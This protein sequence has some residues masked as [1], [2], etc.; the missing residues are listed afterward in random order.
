MCRSAIAASCN[1]VAQRYLSI[2]RYSRGVV[3]SR[4]EVLVREAL[5]NARDGGERV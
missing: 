4:I 3:I 1:A 5:S 2:S